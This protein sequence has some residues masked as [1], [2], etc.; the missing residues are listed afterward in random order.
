M[1]MAMLMVLLCVSRYPA[2]AASGSDHGLSALL[3][4]PMR[5]LPSSSAALYSGGRDGAKKPCLL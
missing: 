4:D 1:F 3:H 5:V 2:E